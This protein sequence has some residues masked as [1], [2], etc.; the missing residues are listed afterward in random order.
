MPR[1]VLLDNV[2]HRHT[3]VIT[4]SGVQ[5]GDSAPMVAVVPREFRQLLGVYPVFLAK[6]AR[7][8][9]F[10]FV[11]LCGFEAGENLFLADDCW[12]ARYVPLEIRRRPFSF[13]PAPG[14]VDDG[15]GD[16]VYIDMDSPRVQETEGERLF[17]EHGGQSP[18]LQSI[19]SNL[20][21]LRVG[22]TAAK[23]LI[24]TLTTLE[25][26]EPVRLDI[27]LKTGEEIALQGLYTVHEEKLRGAPADI[28]IEMHRTGRLR[29]LDFIFASLE[30]LP[31]LIERRNRLA[32]G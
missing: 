9:E 10:N 2:T 25:L 29:E 12:D 3:R 22:I 19:N 7:T 16:M 5:Y 26:V 32:I 23:S 21:E 13:G 11:A 1:H 18:F 4:R 27:G 14:A 17:L 30:Q 31:A 6:D 28:V 20:A 24:A 15:A 8:G